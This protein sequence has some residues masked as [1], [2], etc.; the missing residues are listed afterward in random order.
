MKFGSY[1]YNDTCFSKVTSSQV[2]PEEVGINIS[3]NSC[4]LPFDRSVFV[5]SCVVGSNIFV[6]L[7]QVETLILNKQD[8]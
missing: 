6:L 5:V 8:M 7:G 3:Q 2:L 4:I 1:R